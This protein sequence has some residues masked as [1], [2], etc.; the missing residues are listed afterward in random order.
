MRIGPRAMPLALIAALATVGA[1]RGR[2]AEAP[3]R[4]SGYVEAT[5]VRVAP[6]V[7]G[8]LTEV[9]VSEGDRV[10]VGALI[11][12]LDTADTELAL[13]RA[14]ADRDQAIAAL[15]LL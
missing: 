11:A 14:E 3:E 7:G 13:R 6:Q 15:K 1:C 2:A 5:D 4:A 10:K 8:R 12:K 9:A